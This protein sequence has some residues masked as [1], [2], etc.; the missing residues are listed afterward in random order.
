M[1]NKEIIKLKLKEVGEK[2]HNTHLNRTRLNGIVGFLNQSFHATHEFLV[3]NKLI[4]GYR[5]L[6]C[7]SPV[8]AELCGVRRTA[9]VARS[10]PSRPFHGLLLRQNDLGLSW[11]R[12]RWVNR[13]L[14]DGCG[15]GGHRNAVIQ[16]SRCHC[17]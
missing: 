16:N 6:F 12:R 14:R 10:H 3:P 11:V 4:G 9:V 13:V 5:V 2:K 17:Q 15:R 8:L 7:A 1:K